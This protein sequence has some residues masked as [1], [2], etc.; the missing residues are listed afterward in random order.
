[1][2]HGRYGIAEWF[3]EPFDLMPPERRRTLAAHALQEAKSPAPPCPF[4]STQA[5][6]K[7]GGVCSIRQYADHPASFDRIGKP[8]GTPAI[9]CPKRFEQ[10]AMIARWLAEIAGL[11][12]IYLARE[13]SFMTNPKTGKSAGRIDL[14]VASNAQA[15]QWYALEIQAVYF[16]GPSMSTEFQTLLTDNGTL[17]PAPTDNRRPD[18]RSSSAKRLMP[19]L[20]TKVPTLRQWGKK[21]AV[22]VDTRSAVPAT[23]RPKI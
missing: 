7:K 10:D 23:V 9:T 6:S 21:V 14:V 2:R 20:E 1:M 3:G 17:P 13:V 8:T 4:N 5:C 15:S 22:A 12:E 16:S 18:W 11:G 19:Q